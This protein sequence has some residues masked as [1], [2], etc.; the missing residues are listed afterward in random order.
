MK[1]LIVIDLESDGNCVAFVGKVDKKHGSIEGVEDFFEDLGVEVDT[2]VVDDL[3][4]RIDE[5]GYVR[6]R[7]NF[8]FS[9]I[10]V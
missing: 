5:R 1:K 6:W 2:S 4:H 9:V 7:E 8:C 10:E 3:A